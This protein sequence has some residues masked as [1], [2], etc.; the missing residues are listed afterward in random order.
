MKDFE[1]LWNF[2]ICLLQN[3]TGPKLEEEFDPLS[4]SHIHVV[5][6]T[7]VVL[8]KNFKII[9]WIC[10]EYIYLFTLSFT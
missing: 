8:D 3:V 9:A 10:Y 2:I 6:F 7:N 5:I 4:P 1:W